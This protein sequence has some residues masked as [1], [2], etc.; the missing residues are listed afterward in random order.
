MCEAV[1]C[2]IRTFLQNDSIYE[3][4]WSLV[5]TH[6]NVGRASS[7]WKCEDVLDKF[8]HNEDMLDSITVKPF[9]VK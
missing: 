2:K 5:R 3:K 9:S 6:Q 4:D 1:F 7:T 8:R